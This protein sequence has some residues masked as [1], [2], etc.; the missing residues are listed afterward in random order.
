MV[1]VRIK[2][3]DPYSALNVVPARQEMLNSVVTHLLGKF[4]WDEIQIFSNQLHN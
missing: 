3:R 2:S 1:R 4:L